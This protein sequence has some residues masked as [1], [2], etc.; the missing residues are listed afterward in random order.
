MSIRCSLNVCH[1]TDP[2]SDF[3]TCHGFCK[4][5][6]HGICLN[7]ERGWCNSKLRDNFACDECIDVFV[8]FNSVNNIFFDKITTALDQTS[9]VM[10]KNNSALMQN[11]EIFKEFLGNIENREINFNSGIMNKIINKLNDI[12]LIVKKLDKLKVLDNIVIKHNKSEE[13][14]LKNIKKMEGDIDILKKLVE[15]IDS[16]D[17]K[18][19]FLVDKLESGPSSYNTVLKD[20]VDLL[21]NNPNKS[22]LEINFDNFTL[23]PNPNY[24]NSYGLFDNSS[25]TLNKDDDKIFKLGVYWTRDDWNKRINRLNDQINSREKKLNLSSNIK[26]K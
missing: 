10:H 20:L 4:R 1:N 21:S 9:A 3:V 15:K 14:L 24:G 17:S 18:I 2:K 8:N 25:L 16:I 26:K 11:S 19:N 12:D 7:L 22:D 6:F 13:N 5:K 23:S